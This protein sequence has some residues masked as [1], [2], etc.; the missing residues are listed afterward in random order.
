MAYIDDLLSRV[1]DESL[2]EL[3]SEQI[4]LLRSTRSYGLVFER[5]LPETVPMPS[6]GI[7]VNTIV[8]R[9]TG[10]DRV[11]RVSAIADGLGSLVDVRSG[12]SDSAPVADLVAVKRFGEA[13]F[14]SLTSLGSLTYGGDKPHNIVINSENYHALQ[15]LK[16]LCAG[17]VDVIYMDPPYN[18]GAEDWTYNNRFVD[19]NDYYCHSKWL[20]FI[21]KRLLQARPLLK[22]DG[23]LVVTIDEHEV[24]RLGVLL[25]QLFPDAT[26]TVVTIVINPKGVTSGRFSRV[27]EY[28]YFCFFG[29]SH[30]TSWG[31][32]L[33]TMGAN[34]LEKESNDADEQTRPRWKGLLRSGTNARRQDR[35]KMFYPVLVDPK[36]KAVVGVGDVLAFDREPDLEAKIDGYDAAWPVRND[37][38]LG[39]WGIG[40]GTLKSMIRKGYVRVG[41]YDPKRKTYA[42]TYLSKA[43]QEQIAAGILEIVSYDETRNV[44]D[45]VYADKDAAGRRIKTVWHRTAHDAGAGGTD[46]VRGL[47]GGRV[48]SFPKS[49]Y[50]VRDTLAMLTKHNPEAL[51]L[52]FFAGSGTTLH[53]AG[54]L[55][56]EDGGRRSV[57]LVT[58][59]EVEAERRK[60]L[61]SEG[62]VPGDDEWERYG[63]F[64]RVTRPRVEAAITG[65]SPNGTPVPESLTNA[66]GSPMSLGLKENATFF[67]LGY[68][69]RDSVSLGQAFEAIAPLLWIK[70]GSR[71]ELIASECAAWAAPAAA[72]Y[73][74]L[75]DTAY[76]GPFVEEVS[77][78]TDVAVV[79]VVTDSE[80]EFQQVLADLPP[81]TEPVMLYSDYLRNFELN[82][83]VSA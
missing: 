2:R 55:N 34:D 28:A 44:V 31:D 29:S 19:G 26:I 21:E 69:E 56:A 24:S 14:P 45:V 13:I 62:H 30:L 27:E 12:S 39:N 3:L 53:A 40:P 59:N 67:S 7:A 16:Y 71:G 18:S 11:W 79:Y 25:E 20:S 82:T 63:V 54:M 36:H 49:V 48:F 83:E 72:S 57:I 61:V 77:R 74:I 73:A 23:V 22:D 10:D 75:F 43:P 76:W 78:R 17:K 47:V 66:D 38:S 1:Q 60:A 41:V 80:A 35:K 50:A 51:I 46:V 64:Q 5:H 42:F 70:A 52:D 32:D 8:Q 37:G 58:N 15:T 33:L 81:W 68:L 9:R 4:G 65:V 6:S